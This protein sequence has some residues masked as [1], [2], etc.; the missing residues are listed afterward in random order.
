MELKQRLEL[1][2]HILLDARLEHPQLL[3]LQLA[4]M[5]TCLHRRAIQV[6]LKDRNEASSAP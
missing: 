4:P 1:V 3:L 2:V 5:M 6:I